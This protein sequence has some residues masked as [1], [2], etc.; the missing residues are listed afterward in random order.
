MGKLKSAIL[1][2]LLLYGAFLDPYLGRCRADETVSEEREPSIRVALMNL[3]CEDN[4][5][6]STLGAL[7][8]TV[9]LQA[10]IGGDTR[11]QWVERAELDKV[12]NELHLSAFGQIDRTEAIRGGRWVKADWAVFG[13]ISTN[14]A[15]G[16]SL[17][18]E[19]V[20]LQ[21]A[22][23]LAETNLTLAP[24]TNTYFY[25]AKD[26]ITPAGSALR[27]L[28]ARADR[29]ARKPGLKRRWR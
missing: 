2:G 13:R 29:A 28:L 9:A 3:I 15:N 20:D 5:Y 21:H 6:R 4:S 27:S 26:G 17:N 19:V 11:H 8:F 14:D 7:D 12:E 23:A 24:Q 22:D 18:L 1:N 10:E 25:V 16:R